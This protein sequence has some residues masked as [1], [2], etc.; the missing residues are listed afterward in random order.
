MNMELIGHIRLRPSFYIGMIGD[1]AV[2]S[3]TAIGCLWL[4]PSVKEET[5]CFLRWAVVHYGATTS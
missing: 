3:T 4:W 1:G 5:L 2:R